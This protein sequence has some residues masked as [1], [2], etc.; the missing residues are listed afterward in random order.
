MPNI[1]VTIILKI[2]GLRVQVGNEV[3][4]FVDDI[5]TI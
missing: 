2:D 4:N 5:E 3:E 1:F